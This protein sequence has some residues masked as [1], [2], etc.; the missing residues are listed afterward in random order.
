[1]GYHA[2]RV[3]AGRRGGAGRDGHRQRVR[4]ARRGPLRPPP[5]RDRQRVPVRP[6]DLRDRVRAR[7]RDDRDAALLRRARDRRRVADGHDD[8]RRIHARAA[9]HDDGDRDDRLRAARRD[10]GRPVRARGAAALRLA[11]AVLRGWR[12]AARARLRAGARVARVAALSRATPRTLAGTR[13]AARADAAAGRAGH[14]VHRYEGRPRAGQPRRLRRAVRERPGARHDRAVVRVLHVPARR[15]RGVQLAAD[16]A[17]GERVERVGRGL[18][19]HRVQ[20]RRRDRRVV[21]RMGDR[22]CGLALAA[23]A[24]QHRR[25]GERGVADGC[26]CEPPH[27]LADRRARPARAV[28]QRGAVDDVC[29]VRVHLSDGRAC[30]GHRECA[31]VRPARRDPQRIRGRDRDHGGR[32][33]RVSDDAGRGDGRGVRRAAR[34]AAAHSAAVARARAAARR[35]GTRPPVVVT[36]GA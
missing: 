19:A 23:R 33:G 16:D 12:V 22:A 1:M 10:A 17:R 30:D 14:R 34:G 35:G 15:V 25:R 20:P 9:P 36:A 21:V 7:R 2:R 11:R 3:R 6:R 31:R 18:G 26:R 27:G 8:D 29:A 4:G 13:R 32:R 5:G 24:V 28:R